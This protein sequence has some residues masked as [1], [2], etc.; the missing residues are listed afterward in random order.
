MHACI[1]TYTYI[2]ICIRAGLGLLNRVFFTS[3]SIGGGHC[4]AVTD[5][6]LVYTWG[7]GRYGQLGHGDD[8]DKIIPQP[9]QVCVCVCSHIHDIARV[10]QW[11]R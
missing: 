7:R 11:C 3:I 6:G 9:V 8:V 10:W 4:V 1:H 2:H 5:T